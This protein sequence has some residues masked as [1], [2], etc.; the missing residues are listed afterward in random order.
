MGSAAKRTMLRLP[1]RELVTMRT[2]FESHPDG[3][4]LEAF[5]RVMLRRARST[6]AKDMIKRAKET[7]STLL[8]IPQLDSDESEVDESDE[9]A[10]GEGL[11]KPLL[12][13]DGRPNLGAVN[14]LCEVFD[15]I[16][17]GDGFVGW[18]EFTR[19][20][21]QQGMHQDDQSL[22]NDVYSKR[23]GAVHSV[24]WR[25]PGEGGPGPLRVFRWVPELQK[26]WIG[27]VASWAIYDP[28]PPRRSC[29]NTESLVYTAKLH[30]VT[31]CKL[32]T[33]RD[34][35]ANE[36][37]GSSPLRSRFS[38][39]PTRPA[40]VGARGEDDRYVE[41][42]RKP[43]KEEDEEEVREK[44]GEDDEDEQ[45]TKKKA[46][47][48][49]TAKKG[50][51]STATEALDL[52]FAPCDDLIV[53]LASDKTLRYYRIASLSSLNNETIRAMGATRVP[54]PFTRLAWW[55]GAVLEGQHRGARL[56]FLGGPTAEPTVLAVQPFDPRPK[57]GINHDAGGEPPLVADFSR[58]RGHTDVVTDMLILRQ[59]KHIFTG[60]YRHSGSDDD[61]EDVLPREIGLLAT[62][63]LDRTICLWI[64]PT[65]KRATRLVGHHAGVRALAYDASQHL[66][67]S[68]GFEYGIRAW[69]I[70]GEQAFPIF[71]LEG[72]HF[73]SVRHV[74]AAPGAVSAVV[75]LD[76]SGRLCWPPEAPASLLAYSSRAQEIASVHGSSLKI[77]NAHTGLLD[78]E[79]V[80]LTPTGA[81]TTGISFNA[82]GLRVVAADRSGGVSTH[83]SHDGSLLLSLEPH[84]AEVGALVY[85]PED[86]IIITV[87]WDR[88][89][90]VY[91]ERETKNARDALL[92]RLDNAHDVD[93]VAVSFSRD[94]GLIAT[95]A[96]DNDVRLWDFEDLQLVGSVRYEHSSTAPAI[97]FLD[98]HPVLAIADANGDL[99]LVPITTR[100]TTAKRGDLF[101]AIRFPAFARGAVG[102]ET[103]FVETKKKL[104]VFAGEARGDV[105]VVDVKP[106]LDD[107]GIL[108][109]ASAGAVCEDEPR[110]RWQFLGDEEVEARRSRGRER[111]R[112]ILRGIVAT[113]RAEKRNATKKLELMR[114]RQTT[115]RA[116]GSFTDLESLPHDV[117]EKQQEERERL[118]RQLDGEA[119]WKLSELERIRSEARQRRPRRHK[120]RRRLR[121]R[122]P[123]SKAG[124]EDDDSL[125]S[126]VSSIEPESSSSSSSSSRARRAEEDRIQK[127]ARKREL[128]QDPNDPT[129]WGVGSV[130]REKAMYEH[131]YVELS[132]TKKRVA[133]P[134]P[135]IK[136]P[137]FSAR[138]MATLKELIQPSPFLREKLAMAK[139]TA[140]PRTRRRIESRAPA[141]T[142]A[143]S[144]SASMPALPESRPSITFEKRRLP[145]LAS[146]EEIVALVKE[147][148]IS[149]E[150]SPRG[151]VYRVSQPLLARSSRDVLFEAGR[152][153]ATKRAP[154]LPHFG[155]VS[156][157]T[158]SRRRL[159]A[160]YGPSGC[161]PI[162]N[163]NE[164][165]AAYE[166]AL[167]RSKFGAAVRVD[168]IAR[169]RV[170]AEHAYFRKQASAL[171]ARLADPDATISFRDLLRVFFPLLE[172][173]ELRELRDH[174]LSRDDKTRKRGDDDR[175]TSEFRALF[176]LFDVKQ[177]G[178]IDIADFH[179]AIIQ[180]SAAISSSSDDDTWPV[181][182]RSLESQIKARNH[183]QSTLVGFDDFESMLLS[184]RH[185]A[186]P[187][188]ETF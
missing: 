62:A 25:R 61:D 93:I 136:P 39:Q 50:D 40:M 30:P 148:L 144:S 104:L 17:N 186:D 169:H 71:S 78:R 134:Q 36:P 73:A 29:D 65:C 51:S 70:T 59:P 7:A 55:A 97:A 92:R 45:K 5:V 31:E 172:P 113:K 105:S 58:L 19:F 99:S 137:G 49:K 117:S 107:N 26:L 114:A 188:D 38:S 154:P 16:D 183:Q 150:N 11:V 77:W 177:Q 142:A 95:A 80:S 18:D 174:Y 110:E 182:R 44:E 181:L 187:T 179:R 175:S 43:K 23:E 56:A 81:S 82:R 166:S 96:A 152:R 153:D 84:Q 139:K 90:H 1:A 91:D 140:P 85:S 143:Y 27:A 178:K 133:K 131:L 67:F 94:L 22:A 165:V 83:A 89:V 69:G 33:V 10:E 122:R 52:V 120:R 146:S 63:S 121:S 6:L 135:A 57:P 47:G 86:R 160:E 74:G 127:E 176:D 66:L 161:Y 3:L 128:Q 129:N 132:T 46:T 164:V 41:H 88:A 21:I 103:V 158:S 101:V 124:K 184:L 173:L 79:Y 72:G 151:Y 116:M 8:E 149:G 167:D 75:S 87:S 156:S 170:V 185:D 155:A 108:L 76:D 98:A 112:A 157:S 162:T 35:V 163:I 141:S 171:E 53:V 100:E 48:C 34:I 24:G 130:N 12:A 115:S 54:L 20:V 126:M 168:A 123:A 111:A 159:R 102:L 60:Y 9:P 180:G 118:F 119:T 64:L 109:R 14:D 147:K 145:P 68:S 42:H 28:F 125:L 13:L 37:A 4:T 32:M 2:D 15:R 106:T 138:E